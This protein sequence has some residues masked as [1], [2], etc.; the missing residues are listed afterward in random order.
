MKK[1]WESNSAARYLS[2]VATSQSSLPIFDITRFYGNAW[3]Y[4][5]QH[6][7]QRRWLGRS[8]PR[9]EQMWYELTRCGDIPE[10]NCSW[11][12]LGKLRNNLPLDIRTNLLS[13]AW[14][15]EN[16]LTVVGTMLQTVRGFEMTGA[17]SRYCE[18]CP[19]VDPN[20]LLAELG[21]IQMSNYYCAFVSFLKN[22]RKKMQ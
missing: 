16:H 13:F 17:R 9:Y 1:R 3:R 20:I 8:R 21:P 5:I 7:S 12:Y 14:P 10:K 11:Q 15:S 6:P 18:R 22:K 4:E 19:W 2:Y